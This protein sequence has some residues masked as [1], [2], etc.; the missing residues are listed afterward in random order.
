MQKD[1]A[2]SVGLSAE[3]LCKCE[4]GTL[5]I[6]P[7]SEKLLRIFL[8][9]TVIKHHKIEDGKVKAAFENFFDRLFDEL[10]PVAAFDVEEELVLRFHRA[11]RKPHAD[12]DVEED[13]E[14]PEYE[15]EDEA[16]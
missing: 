3:H 1:V 9:K 5:P 16:A 14:E 15:L 6:S 11:Q 12:N 10:T 8:F 4:A 13:R 2:K 7:G